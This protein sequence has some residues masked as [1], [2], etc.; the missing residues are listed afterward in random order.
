MAPRM[1][2]DPHDDPPRRPPRTRAPERVATLGEIHTAPHWFW[3][4]CEGQDCGHCAPMAIAPFVIR[5]GPNESSDRLRRC[6]RCTVCGR[7]GATLRHPSWYDSQVGWQPFPVR[8]MTRLLG[9]LSE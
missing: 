1:R 6:A 2:R 3:L 9:E 8:Q 7:K 5:W 4:Y